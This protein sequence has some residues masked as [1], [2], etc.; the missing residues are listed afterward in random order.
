MQIDGQISIRTHCLSH[1][2]NH[3]DHIVQCGSRNHVWCRPGGTD[4]DSSHRL[5]HRLPCRVGKFLGVPPPEITIHA[6]TLAHATSQ[7]IVNRCAEFFSFEIPKSHFEGR[8]CSIQNRSIS[9]EPRLSLSFNRSCD[10]VNATAL[11]ALTDC[12]Q[13]FLNL[14]MEVSNRFT[15]TDLSIICFDS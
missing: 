3:I 8:N 1:G 10:V 11:N 15:P 12:S 2:T 6:H 13:C 4:F 9:P 7:Q 5:S 14:F